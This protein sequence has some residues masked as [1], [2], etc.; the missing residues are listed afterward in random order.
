[1]PSLDVN[2]LLKAFED[3]EQAKKDGTYTIKCPACGSVMDV[4]PNADCFAVCTNP[5]CG[6]SIRA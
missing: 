6:M 5:E 3:V 4:H 1:M 2:K